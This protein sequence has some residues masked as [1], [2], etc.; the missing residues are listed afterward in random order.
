MIELPKQYSMYLVDERG[1]ST[2]NK[3]E[4]FDDDV[5]TESN[6]DSPQLSN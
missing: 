2:K 1:A 3:D 6:E 5:E 4:K